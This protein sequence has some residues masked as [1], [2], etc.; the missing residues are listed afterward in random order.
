MSTHARRRRVFLP[1][2]FPMTIL[3]TADTIG[4]VWT[5]CIELARALAA[6]DIRVVVATM[7]A[8]LSN[9]QQ[10][11]AAQAKIQVEAS[12]WKLEWMP[13][14]WRDVDAA[15]E[16]LL[17][18]EKQIAP[19]VVHLNGYAHGVL[20]WRAPLLVAGHSCV[21]SW[22]RAVQN[23]DAPPEWN[24]YREKVRAGLHAADMVVAPTQA[25]LDALREHYGALP[26]TRVIFNGRDEM[27]FG[28]DEDAARISKADDSQAL[29]PHMSTHREVE[30]V[31]SEKEALIL[32]AGRVWDEAKNIAALKRI[33]PRLSWPIFV[34]GDEACP[35]AESMAN[36]Y[37]A[38]ASAFDLGQ[39]G[40][41]SLG[42]LQSSHL[43]RWMKRAAIYALPARYEPFGLSALEAALCGC[44]LVLGDISSLREVWSEAAV[45]VSPHDDDALVGA[46]QNLMED[47]NK[48]CELAQAANKRAQFFTTKSMADAY[49]AS[50]RELVEKHGA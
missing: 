14:P 41:H 49:A 48:R 10:Q 30:V 35:N 42:K 6:H 8:P 44:A 16:W 50:Y 39:N 37:R 5:Y 9:S 38:T 4:G 47:K 32:S 22:W 33:A 17:E 26:R 40:F 20:S 28:A 21:L 3:M 34:A 11:E 43:A 19:D 23:E 15:G 46:L 25:M 18:L 7:G 24:R 27:Q 36:D 2:A 29:A 12:D 13:E 1:F 45:F 31:S